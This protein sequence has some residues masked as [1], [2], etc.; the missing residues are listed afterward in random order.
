MVYS[1]LK[2]SL[3][4]W[5]IAVRRMVFL[6]SGACTDSLNKLCNLRES[7]IRC[8]LNVQALSQHIIHADIGLS[9][10][11]TNEKAIITILL[12]QALDA[13]QPLTEPHILCK[14]SLVV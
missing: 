9:E 13:W 4:G 3:L 5:V 14:C 6:D 7:I 2:R 1:C 11:G 12:Q 10:G 8:A